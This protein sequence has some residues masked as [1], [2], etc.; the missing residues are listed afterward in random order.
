MIFS[1][2]LRSDDAK[3]DVVEGDAPYWLS[4]K[5]G[6][7]KSTLMNFIIGEF[8]P[9]VGHDC[10]SDTMT[11][12]YF[13][14]DQGGVL[15][16]SLIAL[17]RSLLY[18]IADQRPDLILTPEERG[19]SSPGRRLYQH[20]VVPEWTKHRLLNTF[21][22]FLSKMPSS[23]RVYIFIDALDECPDDEDDLLDISPCRLSQTD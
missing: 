11:L 12:F 8:R 1:I 23:S 4:G 15:Q 6:S 2:L 3:A 9:Y 14:W 18:Q 20:H 17:L 22:S 19:H 13:F 16:K 7:G 21:K 10:G 5:P